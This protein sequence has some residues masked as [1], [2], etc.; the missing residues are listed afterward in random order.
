VS[1]ETPEA[2]LRGAAERL[3]EISALLSSDEIEGGAAVKLAQEAAQI[4]ADVGTIAADAAR[5][6][7]EGGDGL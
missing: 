7:S 3:D 6:A 5:A 2:Q 1:A 4:A